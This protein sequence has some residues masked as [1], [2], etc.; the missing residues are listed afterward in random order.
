M[1]G[2]LHGDNQVTFRV[3]F[4]L[5]PEHPAYSLPPP[6]EWACFRLGTLLFN[7]VSSVRGLPA[8]SSVRPAID[9]SG[10]A[11]YGHVESLTLDS[12]VYEIGLEFGIVSIEAEYFSVFLN[13]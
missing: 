6:T 9:A 7:N 10:E 8:Q 4:V 11:D 13:S 12:G 5:A 1:L 2:W 3:D